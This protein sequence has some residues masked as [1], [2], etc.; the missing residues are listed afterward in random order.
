MRRCENSPGI[1]V[2]CPPSYSR[3]ILGFTSSATTAQRGGLPRERKVLADCGRLGASSI[4]PRPHGATAV[5]TPAGFYP[6]MGIAGTGGRRQFYWGETSRA[7]EM[8]PF[9]TLATDFFRGVPIAIKLRGL[10]AI[11]A[12]SA[13]TAPESK[14]PTATNL[15]S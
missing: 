13:L 10:G 4:P 8:R 12:S 5:V 7:F 15:E 11:F 2:V 3:C 1:H 14:I 6:E 9:G